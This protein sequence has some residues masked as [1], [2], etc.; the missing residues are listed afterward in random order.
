MTTDQIVSLLKVVAELLGVL[1]WPAVAVF[2]LIRFG[3]SLREFF[4][5]LGELTFKA[6]GV[7]ATAKRKQVEV[8]AVL[9]AAVATSA[10]AA[11]ETAKESAARARDVADVV[12]ERVNPQTIRKASGSRVLWVDDNPAN[13]ALE[14][15]S[16]E[17][18][19]VEFDLSRSTDD[20]LRRLEATSY[21][22]VI[23]DMGRPPD[24]RAGYTLL[25][26]MRKRGLTTPFIIYA[27]SNAPEHK[28][29]A[30]R[31]GALGSTNRADELFKLVLSALGMEGRKPR[32]GL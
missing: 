10:S 25:D 26:A 14:R 27:S 28:E 5:N 2:V 18:I 29:E 4:G 9:G 7:E 1:A 12:A 17:V 22:A 15:R 30:R 3:P 23:S 8:A 19:G 32:P 6:A 20:A 31:H 11:T 21:D 24:P 16:L 13:N